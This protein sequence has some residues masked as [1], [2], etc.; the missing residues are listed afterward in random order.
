LTATV[1]GIGGGNVLCVTL[2]GGAGASTVIAALRD[3]MK[4]SAASIN[5]TPKETVQIIIFFCFVIGPSLFCGK[6]T[7]KDLFRCCLAI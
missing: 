1:E 4:K 6:K 2:R 5:T 3:I 7:L